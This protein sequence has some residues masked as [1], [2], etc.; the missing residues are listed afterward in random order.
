MARYMTVK[1]VAALFRRS[2]KT[3]YRWI[4]EARSLARS[5]ASTTASSSPNG[6]SG[7]PSRRGGKNT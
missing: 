2:T 6:R 3:I 7:A 4:D 5:S 1:E